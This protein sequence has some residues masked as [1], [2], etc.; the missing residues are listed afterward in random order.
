MSKYLIRT[1]PK[2][3]WYVDEYLIPSML[4]QG[5]RLADISVYND[6]KFEGCLRSFINAC[7]TLPDDDEGTWFLQDD[8]CI[9]KDFKVRTELYDSGYVAGFSSE[10]YDG[11]GRVGAVHIQDMW[12]TF[13]C[14]RI[15]NKVARQCAVWIDKYIIGNVVYKQF[16]ES[17]RNDDW[18]FRT[19]VRQEYP[20]AVALNIAPNL[21]DHVDYLLGGGSGGKRPVEVRAQ[22]WYDHDVVEALEKKILKNPKKL[23]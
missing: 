23:P 9:C 19:F 5:I 18:A 8:V 7:L 14:L 10:R 21:V 3:L 4:K 6:E 15:P 17:G 12:F 1:Y 13:P 22:Y 16:W 20:N 2:R 11:V